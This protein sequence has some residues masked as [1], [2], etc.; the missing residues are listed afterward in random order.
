MER[1]T[2]RISDTIE[3]YSQNNPAKKWR[4]YV[5]DMSLG[6]DIA[7]YVAR[8]K[9]AFPGGYELYAV[10]D[11]GGVLCHDCCKAEFFNIKTAYEGDGWN[12]VGVQT[13]AWDEELVLCGHCNKT[14]FEPES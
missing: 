14:I 5:Y 2:M 13:T 8:T 11:D 6:A 12:V 9:Y 1:K 4:N 10:T 3:V 7:K